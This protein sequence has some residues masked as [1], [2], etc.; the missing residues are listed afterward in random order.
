MILGNTCLL[1]RFPTTTSLRSTMPHLGTPHHLD[2]PHRHLDM[3]LHLQIT[4]GIRQHNKATRVNNITSHHSITRLQDNG[5]SDYKEQVNG[6][7][8]IIIKAGG[9]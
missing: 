5:H 7:S 8:A 3:L 9:N 4:K 2:M 6:I 1:L